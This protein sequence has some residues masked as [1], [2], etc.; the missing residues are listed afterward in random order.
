MVHLVK[1]TAALREII[2][3]TVDDAGAMRIHEV[4]QIGPKQAMTREGFLLCKDVPV[5]RVGELIYVAGELP[6]EAGPDHLIRVVRTDADLFAPAFLDSL[7]GKPVVDMMAAGGGSDGDHPA[8]DVTPANWRELAAGVMLNA[9]RGDAP[10]ADCILC[11]LLITDSQAINYVRNGKRGVSLG[12]DAEYIQT[13]PGR[14]LQRPVAANHVVLT[15]SPR[16]G[17]R[18]SIGDSEMSKSK[19]LRSSTSHD[20]ILS[21]IRRAFNTRDAAELENALEE[22]G[23]EKSGGE[24]V[25]GS[26]AVHVHVYGGGGE[27][28]SEASTSGKTETNDEG[29][30]GGEGSKDPMKPVMDALESLGS[31][32]TALEEKVN[33]KTTDADDEDD[34]DK[35][36]DEDDEGGDDERTT[37]E[38]ETPDRH[39]GGVPANFPDGATPKGN[40]GD[41]AALVKSYQDTIA[42]AEL[43]APGMTIPTFD[44][45]S[46]RA[47]TIDSMCGIRRSALK[48][49]VATTDGRAFADK[50]ELGDVSK[51]GCDAI[52]FAFR[53]ASDEK[54]QRTNG[55]TY[56]T[57]SEHRTYGGSSDRKAPPT[58]AE[59]N[60]KHR[61]KYGN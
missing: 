43:L 24:D 33:G 35:D 23:I 30:E 36:A 1:P 14:A 44:A 49:F 53:A 10:L 59:L 52:G 4:M 32:M 3:R 60:A 29:G 7:N 40:T 18:C 54:K 15:S 25:G 19:V 20:S 41:S 27:A 48:K 13:A 11:D 31:R 39:E 22:S 12:Y 9:R 56:D 28:G 5:A 37:D 61:A 55:R 47:K 50:M 8:E 26:G 17:P 6:V 45:K 38:G 16:C 51:L 42:R 21:R 58:P 57:S 2:A 46:K 34:K